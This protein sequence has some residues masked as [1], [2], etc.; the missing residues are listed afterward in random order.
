MIIL[1]RNGLSTHC[2]IMS[3]LTNVWTNGLE[4]GNRLLDNLTY[5][6]LFWNTVRRSLLYRYRCRLKSSKASSFSPSQ[7]KKTEAIVLDKI[8]QFWIFL[9]PASKVLCCYFLIAPA[10][11]Q[12]ENFLLLKGKS[13]FLLLYNCICFQ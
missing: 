11:V 1:T 10:H 2:P 5:R 7:S 8:N 4:K 9:L 13:L 3:P 6:R 12:W